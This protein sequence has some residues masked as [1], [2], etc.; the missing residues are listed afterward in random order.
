MGTNKDKQDTRGYQVAPSP[1]G[2]S[3]AQVNVDPSASPARQEMSRIR[4]GEEPVEDLER[5]VSGLVREYSGAL[6]AHLA[7]AADDSSG[8]DGSES[9]A[10]RLVNSFFEQNPHKRSTQ[11]QA[12]K[13]PHT[14]HEASFEPI[15]ELNDPRI[16]EFLMRFFA[17]YFSKNPFVP[18]STQEFSKLFGNNRHIPLLNNHPPR[19]LNFAARQAFVYIFIPALERY[20]LKNNVSWVQGANKEE[21]I[22]ERPLTI[23]IAPDVVLAFQIR[24][25]D[26]IRVAPEDTPALER[27]YYSIGILS[28]GFFHSNAGGVLDYLWL[29]NVGGSNEADFRLGRSDQQEGSFKTPEPDFRF[30]L[31][32][33]AHFQETGAFPRGYSFDFSGTDMK[34]YATNTVRRDAIMVWSLMMWLSALLYKHAPDVAAS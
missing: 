26:Y 22:L 9:K 11:V 33:F 6:L 21:R 31:G 27:P 7:A 8:A 23:E 17:T 30:Q 28:K 15:A 18:I 4:I 25:Q 20:A 1:I 29:N 16:G 14:S 2:R 3:K 34:S 19:D 13:V 24:S 12:G 32:N 5:R 10:V